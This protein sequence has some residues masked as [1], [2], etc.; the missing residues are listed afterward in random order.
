MLQPVAQLPYSLALRIHKIN[1]GSQEKLAAHG[2]KCF[3]PGN[4]YPN[5]SWEPKMDFGVKAWVQTSA[6]ITH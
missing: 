4:S 2:T 5:A 3:K 1:P 6:P